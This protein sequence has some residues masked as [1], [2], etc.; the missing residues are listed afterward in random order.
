MSDLVAIDY[1]DPAVQKA[2]RAKARETLRYREVTGYADGK[3]SDWHYDADKVRCLWCGQKLANGAKASGFTGDGPDWMTPEGDFGCDNSPDS[4]D[5]SAGGHT[6][7][8]VATW[9]GH[10]VRVKYD[11]PDGCYRPLRHVV[12]GHTAHDECLDKGKPYEHVPAGYRGAEPKEAT[13]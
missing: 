7:N 4:T 2:E 10:L 13:A 3:R 9:D 12:V 1:S 11:D 6:P 8:I 5:E